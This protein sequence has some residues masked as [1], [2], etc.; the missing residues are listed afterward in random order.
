MNYGVLTMPRVDIRGTEVT[1]WML[2]FSNINNELR[3]YFYT[4]I[5]MV[6]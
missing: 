6:A 4:A 5:T 1:V 3:M 2:I